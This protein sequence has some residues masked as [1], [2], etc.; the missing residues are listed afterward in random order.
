[1]ERKKIVKYYCATDGWRTSNPCLTCGAETKEL[2][3]PARRGNLYYLRDLDHPVPSVT[4][5]LQVLAKPQLVYWAAK[6]A[7][8]YALD[9]PHSS[10]EEAASSINRVKKGAGN[11]GTDV[12]NLV[13]HEDFTN[14]PPELSGYIESYKAFKGSMPHEILLSEKIVYTT[15]WAG[16]FDRYVKMGSRYGLLDY[17]TTSDL[18]PETGIQIST[19]Q[20]GLWIEDSPGAKGRPWD[21][22][23]DFRMG[24][25]LKADGT[26]AIKEYPD[27]YQVFQN[28]L[29]VYK[30]QRGE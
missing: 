12:H 28:L 6:T 9:K 14:V 17:K 11:R 21:S 5:V 1:M 23:I 27:S 10:V 26:F 19:Y 15:D 18:Y 29:A 30:W 22:P 8:E 4:S 20:H 24:V 16:K 3:L 2:L 7:A 25:Q 13:E